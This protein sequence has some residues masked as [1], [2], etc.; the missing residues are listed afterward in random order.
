MTPSRGDDRDKPFYSAV[1]TM[2]SSKKGKPYP[3]Q[4][5]LRSNPIEVHSTDVAKPRTH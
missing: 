2:N 3:E 5:A 1:R 4:L